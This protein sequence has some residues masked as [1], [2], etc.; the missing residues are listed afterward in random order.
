MPKRVLIL[1]VP[2]DVVTLS[3][4][5]ARTTEFLASGRSHHVTTPNP[6][7]LV[8][9]ARNN[10]FRTVLLSSDLNIPD[11]A[12]LLWAARRAGTVLPERVAGVDLLTAICS[13][14][15]GP[16]FLLGA[17]PGVAQS[18]AQA[19]KL[20]SPNL[21]IA[22]TFSGSPA[23][24]EAASIVER[25]NASGARILFVAYGAP[26]Q[27][28][29]IHKHLSSMPDLRIAMGVGGAFDFFAGV[30][31][32]APLWI[33]NFHLEWLW[34]LLQE[35]RRIKRIA[36]AVIIFPWM[37]LTSSRASVRI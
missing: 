34:R 31:T 25:V 10:A 15:L 22:G 28:L 21:R 12:G 24:S 11:G 9:A 23:E 29:W 1:G 37:V 5:V 19:L 13:E 36:T 35:P 8:E 26:V 7:M 20:Q 27:D 30:R 17:K 6:E 3:G 33:Q 14:G 4:A 16:V 2:V 18:A 32:R